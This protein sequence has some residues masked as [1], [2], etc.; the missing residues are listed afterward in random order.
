[1][2]AGELKNS[3]KKDTWTVLVVDDDQE[4]HL[5]TK[6]VLGSL[7]FEGNGIELIST[8]SGAEALEIAAERDDIAVALIDVVME[9]DDAGLSLVKAIRN[10]LE[11][12]FMRIILRTGQPGQ[13]PEERVIIDYDINDYKEKT[14]LTSQKLI[15]SI[16][17]AIR[18]YSDLLTIAELNKELEE[19]V[20]HRT[21]S[22]ADANVK[23]RTYISRLESDHAAGG[24]VQQ[25]LLP[26]PDKKF[27]SYHF[28]SKLFS[29][30]YL[31]GDFLDYFEIDSRYLGFYM[32]DVSGHGISSAFITVILKNFMDTLLESYRN[33][34][35]KT[36][37][38]PV[39]VAQKMNRE[40][41]RENLGKYLTIF[42]A[43]LDHEKATLTY[44]N[45]GQ[46]PYPII[47]SEKNCFF[48]EESG[49]PVGLFDEPEFIQEEISLPDSFSLLLISDGVLELLPQKSMQEKS[50]T[51]LALMESKQVTIRNLTNALNLDTAVSFPDDVTFLLMKREK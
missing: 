17:A 6:M 26:A 2:S 1:M 12:R 20:A 30:M 4:V 25:K 7:V 23:L 28:S 46:F 35:E 48:I 8:Y 31:S 15:T 5:V 47:C 9:E 44:S 40:I 19:K 38:E 45:C 27:G 22:L 32:A 11:N 49:T 16:I 24:R 29:S 33:E 14:E 18:S 43:V 41:L 21:Q 51:L 10:D 39:K 50:D 3:K 37:L 42:Y 36:I 34:S 13:A